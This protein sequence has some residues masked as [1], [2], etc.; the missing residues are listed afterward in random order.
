MGE[1]HEERWVRRER[2]SRKGGKQRSSRKSGWQ[3]RWHQEKWA[4][5][6]SSRRTGHQERRAPAK[7][8][9]KGDGHEEKGWEKEMGTGRRGGKRRWAQGKL[10]R[11][12]GSASLAAPSLQLCHPWRCHAPRN[13]NLKNKKTPKKPQIIIIT[14]RDSP[15]RAPP[16][17]TLL[18]AVPWHRQHGR[19]V[20]PE[21]RRVP[22]PDPGANIASPARAAIL[23]SDLRA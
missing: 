20:T 12:G 9:G 10:G 17:Q 7:V 11:K 15:R 6:S 23:G 14:S 5:E 2:G 18:G 13:Q 3:G 16:V 21:Q 4:G 19:V 1:G 22:A 8:G